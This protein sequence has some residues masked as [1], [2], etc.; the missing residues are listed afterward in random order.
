LVFTWFLY[1]AIY[2][3]IISDNSVSNLKNV[4]EF[5]TWT[6]VRQF[7]VSRPI[8]TIF[9]NLFCVFRFVKK[10]IQ[11]YLFK[12]RFQ[13]T[14]LLWCA[15]SILVSRNTRERDNKFT[16][17]KQIKIICVFVVNKLLDV[18]V[19]IIIKIA[20]LSEIIYC[21]LFS[22]TRRITKAIQNLVFKQNI[23]RR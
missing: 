1:L 17:T 2:L 7:N 12:E 10:N 14:C 6:C 4:G 20:R 18:I 15:L 13:A 22:R 16:F 9:A 8:R 11:K 23:K 19:I 3:V 5:V 21:N